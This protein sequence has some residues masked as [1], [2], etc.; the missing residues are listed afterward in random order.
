VD[1]KLQAWKTTHKDRLG[2]NFELWQKPHSSPQTTIQIQLR[3]K[4]LKWTK[5]SNGST[6]LS[7]IIFSPWLSSHLIQVLDV[8]ILALPKASAAFLSSKFSEVQ[9]LFPAEQN[10]VAARVAGLSVKCMTESRKS[11]YTGVSLAVEIEVMDTSLEHDCPYNMKIR[12]KNYSLIKSM[13]KM[14]I[15]CL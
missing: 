1:F 14:K 7:D 3:H 8:N 4:H 9:G 10:A 6:I 12:N 13:Q 2:V 11:G 5:Y 15:F